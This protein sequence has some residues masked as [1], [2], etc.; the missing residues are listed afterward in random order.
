M[1][2]NPMRWKCAALGCYNELARPKIE[3][4]ADCFPGRIC[5]G[6]IDGLVEI[7]GKFLLLE[8]KSGPKEIPQ[9]QRITYDV[10]VKIAGR[11]WTVLCIAGD[12]KTMDVT[13]A[14]VYGKMAR[15]EHADLWRCKRY[16]ARWARWANQSRQRL[17]A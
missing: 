1:G 11:M 3:V 10:L 2:G 13:H 12:A 8:W 15:W 17:A 6:D 9:G 4:F 7:N 16:M 14:M 5:M